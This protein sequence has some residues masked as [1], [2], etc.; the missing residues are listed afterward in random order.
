MSF[1]YIFLI[2]LIILLIFYYFFYR[3]SINNEWNIFAH[4]IVNDCFNLNLNF[5]VEESDTFSLINEKNIHYTI[6][7]N[8]FEKKNKIIQGLAFQIAKMIS[9]NRR[10]SI[11]SINEKLNLYLLEHYKI[12]IF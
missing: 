3:K 6:T 5:L 9:K 8:K 10:L 12:T 7:I 1:F 2:I 11:L 4:Q